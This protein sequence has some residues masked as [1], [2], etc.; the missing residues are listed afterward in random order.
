[1]CACTNRRK[2]EYMKE[3][4]YEEL[5]TIV[6]GCTKNGIKILLGYFN[7]KVRFGDQDGLAVGNFGIHEESND[8]RLR[9]TGLASAL[10]M[11]IGDTTSSHKKIH[12]ATWRCPDGTTLIK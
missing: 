7:A 11:V 1:M 2:N 3:S 5:E 10:N 4:F 8:N 6:T 12:L 9:L